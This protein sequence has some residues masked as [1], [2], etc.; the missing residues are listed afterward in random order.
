MPIVPVNPIEPT[1]AVSTAMMSRKIT[2]MSKLSE[3]TSSED[4]PD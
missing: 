4:S 3:A 2:S 1:V